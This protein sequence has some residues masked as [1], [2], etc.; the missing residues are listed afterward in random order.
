MIFDNTLKLSNNQ[1][2]TETA[3]SENVIDL[4]VAGRN[5]GIGQ[6]I[7][8]RIAVTEDFATLT[9]LTVE[10]Q[11]ADDEA[12]SSPV[13]V[14]QTGAIAAADLVS[15]YSFNI[16]SAPKGVTGRY[17]RLN[18]T[19]GGSNATAGKINAGVTMGNQENG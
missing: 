8:L 17:M 5:V 18:Y 14:V 9:S 11:T 2:V 7:P 10:V 16:D 6:N 19:V 1:A 4:G 13:T 12:F 15:G 3:V